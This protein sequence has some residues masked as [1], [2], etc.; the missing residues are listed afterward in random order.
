MTRLTN[1]PT[2]RG[3][4]TDGHPDLVELER[5]RIDAEIDEIGAR[6]AD[7]K[8]ARTALKQRRNT[9]API[10]RLPQDVSRTIFKEV[11][12]GIEPA[13]K[14]EAFPFSNPKTL[15]SQ[16]PWIRALTH[17]CSRWR[18]FAINT[19]T[20]WARTVSSSAIPGSQAG[21]RDAHP[22]P[23]S[24]DIGHYPGYQFWVRL[25]AASCPATARTR[26]IA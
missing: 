10:S 17:V 2:S 18:E 6:I 23:T 25:W 22:I 14:E 9:L 12:T 7:L 8:L 1:V 3:S 20:L 16:L 15:K 21:V 11:Q 26:I 19:P 4:W 13:V 24:S 5:S